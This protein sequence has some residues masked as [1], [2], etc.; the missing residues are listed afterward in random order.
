MRERAWRLAPVG[1]GAFAVVVYLWNLTVSGWANAYYSAAAQAASQSWP[2]LFFGALDAAGFI[3]VDK[4][5]LSLWLMGLSVRLLGL[6]PFAVLLPQALAGVASVLVLHAAVRRQLG[7]EAALIAGV[8][9]AITPVAAL[10]FRYNNPDAVL[11]LLLVSAAWAVIRGLEDGRLRWPLLAA[12][13][14]GSAF[15]VKYLQAYLVLPAFVLV[16]LVAAPGSVRRRI[17]VL[18][19]S[20]AVVV[21][22][23]A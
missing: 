3:T 7:R 10:M 21:V 1:L 11:V 17:G 6:S 22:S 2:A 14:V 9:F 15:L 23:S 8:A 19:A 13:L 18:L 5:P 4:P 20:G 12:V 16:W